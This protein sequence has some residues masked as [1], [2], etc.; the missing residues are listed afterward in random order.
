MKHNIEN[1]MNKM[2]IQNKNMMQTWIASNQIKL[3][4]HYMPRFNMSQ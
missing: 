1:M 2:H 4:I 3:N